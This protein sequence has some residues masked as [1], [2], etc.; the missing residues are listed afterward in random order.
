MEDMAEK[1]KDKDYL[2]LPNF[3]YISFG[4]R[5]CGNMFLFLVYKM[6]RISFV[7]F[8]FYFIPFFAMILSYLVPWY[9][10]TYHAAM[11]PAEDAGGD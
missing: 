10:N 9:M 6:F 4:E 1:K 7:T 5:P 11:K 3:I 8:W 2:E